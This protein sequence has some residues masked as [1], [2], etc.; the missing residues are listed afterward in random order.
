MPAKKIT[1]AAVMAARRHLLAAGWDVAAVQS[2]ADAFGVAYPV[3][4]AACCG[5]T[6]KRL[7][8]VVAPTPRPP[9]RPAPGWAG[10]L[11]PADRETIKA[12]L[13]AGEAQ[14]VVHLDY[15]GVSRSTIQKLKPKRR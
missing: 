1:E 4:A 13:R 15:P 9:A 6:F 3:A 8:P 5:L 7:N 11:T 2:L 14:A 10:K 12:R